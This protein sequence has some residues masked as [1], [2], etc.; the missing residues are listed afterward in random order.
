MRVSVTV[1]QKETEPSVLSSPSARQILVLVIYEGKPV[2]AVSML[3]QS[4]C[5]VAYWQ[6]QGII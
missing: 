1:I 5:V 3:R 6:N 4:L 2:K